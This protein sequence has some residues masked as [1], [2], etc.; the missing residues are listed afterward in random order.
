MK[1]LQGAA[2]FAHNDKVFTERD[3]EGYKDIGRGGKS[4]DV[5]SIGL[6]GRGS[7]SMYHFTN[8][9]LI[10]SDK[11]LLIVDP[12]QQLLPRGKYGKRKVGLKLLLETVYRLSADLLRPFHGMGSFSMEANTNHYQGTLFRLPLKGCSSIEQAMSGAAIESLFQE[13]YHIA[14]ESLLF[15]RHVRSISY[16]VR[17]QAKSGWAIRAKHPEDGEQEIFRQVKISGLQK[18]EKTFEETWRIGLHDLVRAPPNVSRPAVSKLKV[19]ECGVAA[20][21]PQ[22]TGNSSGAYSAQERKFYNKLLTTY[23]TKMP[24]ALHATFAVTGTYFRC[25]IPLF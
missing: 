3:F 18:D 22:K 5:D 21:L 8:S 15:L 12:Y 1:A 4:E 20:C 19:I 13:Y 7:M 2:L 16:H 23:D 25:L 14:C 9:P 6:F 11:W 17:G 24:V 10:L